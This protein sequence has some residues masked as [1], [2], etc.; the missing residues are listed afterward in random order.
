MPY[1]VE[2]ALISR[3]HD[4][5]S[6]DDVMRSLASHIRAACAAVSHVDRWLFVDELRHVADAWAYLP[7]CPWPN[8]P[9]RSGWYLV[10]LF[11]MLCVT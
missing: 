8:P 5:S 3:T 11:L 1:D 7:P 2:C 6:L 4:G 10:C 9:G